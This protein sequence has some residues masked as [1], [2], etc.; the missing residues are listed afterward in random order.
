VEEKEAAKMRPGDASTSRPPVQ[1]HVHEDAATGRMT[2]HTDAGEREL[3]RADT[4]RMH[5]DAAVC[6]HGGR[7]TM[8]IPPRTRREVLARDQ[9]RC[10][11]PDCGRTQFLEVHHIVPRRQGGA[12]KPDNLTTL[13]GA[14]HRLFHERRESSVTLIVEPKAQ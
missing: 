2:V 14:C 7:N 4:E 8:T 13:C 10:Q 11:S 6:E 12:N 1:I 9:H 3:G 5:C